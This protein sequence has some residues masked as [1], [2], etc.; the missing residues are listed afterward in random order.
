MSNYGI[1]K[2][3]FRAEMKNELGDVFYSLITVA[4]SVNIDL[5]E[6]LNT[7]IKKYEKRLKT[8]GSAGS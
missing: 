2:I 8:T 6:A 5:E 1:K 3:E 4:N 7:A